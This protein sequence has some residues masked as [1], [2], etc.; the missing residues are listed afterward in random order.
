MSD[1]AE[2]HI[3]LV[4]GHSVSQRMLCNALESTANITLVTSSR[5]ARIN[6]NKSSFDCVIMSYDQS[7]DEEFLSFVIDLRRSRHVMRQ[8]PV[9][10]ITSDFSEDMAY[11]AQCVGV[12][13]TIAKPFTKD[14]LIAAV[15]R[16][17]AA[18]GQH[19]EKI[20]RSST[21]VTCMSWFQGGMHF[22][23]SP[24]L[25]RLV[26]GPTRKDAD[27]AMDQLLQQFHWQLKDSRWGEV[28]PKVSRRRVLFDKPDE[29][30]S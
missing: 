8:A 5:D 9:L 6:V 18:D 21:T 3:L 10:F 17:I 28:V 15:K 16:H 14:D 1:G 4:D 13:Q 19:I 7:H 26:S 29:G 2:I 25:N 24:D 23:F 11:R 20:E 27:Q 22:V 12:N 30:S